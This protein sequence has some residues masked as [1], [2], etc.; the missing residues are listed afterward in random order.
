[1]KRSL[2]AA[3]ILSAGVAAVQAHHSFAMFD[4]SQ[5]M[6][7]KGTVTEFQWT[8]PH[9]FIHMEVPGTDGKPELWQIEL[10]SPNNLK[11]QGWKSSSVKA[12]D[13]ITLIT[14]P[15]RDMSDHK[16]GLFIKLTRADGTELTEAAFAGGGPV[17]VPTLPPAPAK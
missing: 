2:V 17:N 3:L 4:Q 1:M 5:R 10:N 8:N 13:K 15:L 6:T 16:G 14:N 7:L 9:A 12:G 11:R